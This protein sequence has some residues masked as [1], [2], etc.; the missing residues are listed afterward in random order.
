MSVSKVFRCFICKRIMPDY[1]PRFCCSGQEC[2]CRGQRINPQTCS[3]RCLTA[4]LHGTG[5]TMEQRRIDAGIELAYLPERKDAVAT[6]TP[7]ARRAVHCPLSVSGVGSRYNPAA[8][9]QWHKENKTSSSGFLGVQFKAKR[10]VYEAR[11]LV[12]GRTQKSYAGTAK[13]AEAAARMYDAKAREVY[14][15][16]A[17]VN[18]EPVEERSLVSGQMGV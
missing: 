4:Y 13:T 7:P 2:E 12:P 18:F 16:G 1:K 10:G 6:G 3:Q 5:E 17:A 15:P 8:V 14:G 11:I 9:T